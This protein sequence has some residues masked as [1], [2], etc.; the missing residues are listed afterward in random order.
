MFMGRLLAPA[1]LRPKGA[2]GTQ[3]V[4]VSKILLAYRPGAVGSC[5]Q[6]GRSHMISE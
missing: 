5:D 2:A 6:T 3:G 1:Y 4:Q